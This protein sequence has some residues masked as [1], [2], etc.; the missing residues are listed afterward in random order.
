MSDPS[1]ENP[2]QL[3]DA[4]SEEAAEAL[5]LAELEKLEAAG[6]QSGETREQFAQRLHEAQVTRHKARQANRKPGTTKGL[7]I[8]NTGNGKGKTTAALGVVFRA[9]GRGMR[10]CMLQF[11]KAATAN[12]GETRAA[13]QLGIEIIAMGDGF[14]WLSENIENDKALARECWELCKQK[15]MSGDYDIVILDE[16]T[17]TLSYGW[18]DVHEVI[19]TLKARPEG[20]HIIITG[21]NA[22]PELIEY[23]DMV[24]EMTEVKHPYRQGILA[25]KGIEF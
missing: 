5:D 17:Y 16:M 12:W 14:T 7:V 11:I 20:Q 4:A 19:E 13:R 3:E 25:Q 1:Q 18:L 22:V 23:A 9:W 10:V 24:T 2:D 15:I 21:R 8:I 6:P